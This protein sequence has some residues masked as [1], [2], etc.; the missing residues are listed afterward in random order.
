MQ[1]NARL[2]FWIQPEELTELTNTVGNILDSSSLNETDRT[3]AMEINHELGVAFTRFVHARIP[4]GRLQQAL[5]VSESALPVHFSADEVVFLQR[6][7]LS[8]NLQERLN[9]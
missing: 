5:N 4:A 7:P 8:K 1:Y 3:V 9:E 6:L 2:P